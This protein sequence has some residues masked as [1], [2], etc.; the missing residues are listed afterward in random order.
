M[1][2][3]SR[4]TCIVL[5]AFLFDRYSLLTFCEN[6]LCYGRL[7]C[8]CGSRIVL[9]LEVETCW[10]ETSVWTIYWDRGSGDSGTKRGT[11]ERRPA[12]AQNV[13][14]T[15][16]ERSA[17]DTSVLS[18]LPS[19]SRFR[20]WMVQGTSVPLQFRPPATPTSSLKETSMM[21]LAVRRQSARFRSAHP[22]V[23]SSPL[24]THPSSSIEKPYALLSIS[25][26]DLSIHFISEW[27]SQLSTVSPA[28]RPLL[29]PPAR[30]TVSTEHDRDSQ[31]WSTDYN[32]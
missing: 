32:L 28:R 25:C 8:L 23:A 16:A 24:D 20:L 4:T 15:K 19:S 29:Y 27:L 9:R 2:H 11:N 7:Y 6:I 10:A 13:V 30:H 3:V 17:R 1:I 26:A 14:S 21:S 18:S 22:L 5:L 12:Y 31:R